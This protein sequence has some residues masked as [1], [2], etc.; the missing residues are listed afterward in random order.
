MTDQFLDIPDFLRRD[1]RT[2]RA[3][4]NQALAEWQALL[5][6]WK[7]RD[8]KDALIVVNDA[9]ARVLVAWKH[10]HPLWDPR[11]EPP[12]V[13]HEAWAEAWAFCSYD[14]ATLASISRTEAGQAQALL[15]S[16]IGLR[17]VFPDGEIDRNA[18]TLVNGLVARHIKQARAT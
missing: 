3:K 6:Q 13:D 7:T 10:A 18:Q 11:G 4:E 1:A 15:A 17:L 9:M 16:A 8:N 14:A 2:V 12:A 5:E